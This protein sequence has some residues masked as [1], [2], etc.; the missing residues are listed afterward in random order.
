MSVQAYLWIHVHLWILKKLEPPVDQSAAAGDV[1]LALAMAI[2]PSTKPSITQNEEKTPGKDPERTTNPR[3]PTITTNPQKISTPEVSQKTLNFGYLDIQNP[4][5]SQEP[6]SVIGIINGNPARI[7][8]D[9]GCSTYVLS[10]EFAV[11]AGIRQ[12]PTTPVAVELAVRSAAQPTLKTQ[13]KEL[14][15]SIGQFE[16][17]KALYIAPL[18]RYDAILGAP[19]VQEF[20]VRFPQ[21]PVA[22]IKGIEVPLIQETQKPQKIQMISRAKLK[23]L[24]RRDQADEIYIANVRISD[25]TNPETPETQ[26][27]PETPGTQR[28]PETPEKPRT[29]KHSEIKTT[30]HDWIQEEFGDIFLDGLPPGNPPSRKVEHEIPLYPN[31]PPPFKGIFRLSQTELQELRTQLQQLL[32]DGKISPSTSPYGAPV[33]FVKK[34]DGSLRMCIDY[35]ALNS[36]TVKNRYALPRIDELFDR[37]HG[38]KVFSKIDLTSGYWQIAIAEADRPK[39]AFRTRYG[40]YE[41]NVMPFGLTNAPA[42]F[43]TLMNDIFRDMLD[44]C[45][46]VYMDDILVYSKTPEEHDRHLRQV[47]Q[48]LREHQLY[49]KPSKCTLFTDTID[50]LGH[51]VTPEGIKPNPA[52]VEAIVKYP[53][54]ETLKSLQSF[55]GMTNYYRK[56]VKDYSKRALPLTQ[57]LQNASNSRPIIWNPEME[58]AFRDLKNALTNAPCLQLPDPDDEFEVTTDASED[59]KAVGCV[60]MQNGHP[61]AFESKKLNPHQLNYTVHDKEMCAIMHALTLWRPFLLGRHFKVYTDHRSL[62]HLKTQ[63]NLNQRQIRWMEQAADYD[64]EILY[65]PGKENVVADALSRIQINALSPLPNKS[66]NATVIE[67][68]KKE[69]FR[70]LIQRVGEKG[71]TTERYKIGKDKLLYYRTDEYEPWRLCLPDIPYRKKVIHDN[72]DL[73]IA[74]HPGFIQTYAKIARLYYWPGMSA[75]IRRHV[76]ECDACQRTKP[77]TQK[78]SGELQPLPIP[79]RPW[80]SIGMDYLGPLPVSTNGHD[81]ILI[82]ID[83]LTKMA[84]FIPTTS[85]VTSK[86]TA[87][88]FLQYVFRYHGL[89]ENIVSDRDP[90][91]TSRF[92][93]NL[94]K[95]LGVNIL[96][97]TSAHPQTDGQSE[98]TVKIIQKLLKPFCLQ[99]QD[100]EELLPSLEFAYNDTKQSSTHET[101]FYLNYG[102]HPIG[103]YRYS[104]TNNPHVE[105]YVQY[106]VRLQEAARDAIHDTQTIQER[107]ANKHRQPS[108]EIKVGDWVLLRRRKEHQTKLAP[109]ADGP[110]QVL[111]IGTNNVTLKLPRRSQAHPTVNISRVQLYFGPRPE[112]L[113]EPPKDNTEHEYPIERVM[114]HKVVK[115]KDYY[116]IHWKGYPAEDD[117]WEPRENLTPEA[118]RSWEDSVKTRSMTR[119][120][121]GPRKPR[122]PRKPET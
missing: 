62:T 29:E 103:T 84:H 2:E 16:T 78:P 118:L 36:Q 100:W 14:S 75:N 60:L 90:K 107:Y 52:L 120:S 114:G 4:P 42:T 38:A 111:K 61:V 85:N 10:E 83:R 18:P 63:P 77:S 67:S 56:F 104:D 15:M 65:K 17:R 37:L 76:K 54:P 59:A 93:K 73:A 115:G 121:E 30:N 6:P 97:S 24:V 79:A 117:S 13:T 94:T 57:A 45:V 106:L 101:P 23:K 1:A 82:A 69:P 66:L 31:L 86:Q 25:S 43:Q 89:P 110:F 11:H 5:D 68:Y 47:L 3:K 49:A 122:K 96:M 26:E 7:L 9:S 95:A 72:H 98:A 80:Q 70:S 32:Q 88:L 48:R 33:L 40:H 44:I 28:T 116:Y 34:K 112:L 64:C 12:Y 87:E 108:P 92:W 51:L 53:R 102:Y 39:T 55:L 27:K 50:Y 19:F 105:D 35:R 58:E 74:G 119:N 71:G 46:I 20:G 99:E 41:F 113:T 91:F 81:M 8:L 22:V 21:N 109:I